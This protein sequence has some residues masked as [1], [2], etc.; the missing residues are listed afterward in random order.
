MMKEIT[1]EEKKPLNKFEWIL[2]TTTML[3]AIPKALDASQKQKPLKKIDRKHVILNLSRT[4]KM[5]VPALDVRGR[6]A[7]FRE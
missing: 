3:R 5:F 6:I 1:T 4:R 7:E 2:F